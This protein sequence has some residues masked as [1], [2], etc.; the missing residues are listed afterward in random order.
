VEARVRESTA[1]ECAARTDTAEPDGIFRRIIAFLS[2]RESWALAD[3]AMVS[4]ANFLSG[5]LVARLVGLRE[6]GVFSLAWT[7][8]LFVNGIQSALITAPMVSVGPILEAQIGPCYYAAVLL[9]QSVFACVAS[10]VVEAGV[11]LSA[12]F[13]PA[14]GVRPLALPLAVSVFAYQMQDFMRRYFFATRREKLGFL[15][16]A[17][18]FLPQVLILAVLFRSHGVDSRIALWVMGLTSLA[19]FVLGLLTFGSYKIE[20]GAVRATASRHWLSS[21]WLMGSAMVQWTSGNFFLPAAAI[22][23]GPAAAGGVRAAQTLG[24]VLFVLFNSL[25]NYLPNEAA[26]RFHQRG[27][28]ALRSYL[29]TCRKALMSVAAVLCLT[30]ALSGRWLLISLYGRQYGGFAGVLAIMMATYFLTSAALP[31]RFGLRVLENTRPLFAAQVAASVLTVGT[32]FPLIAH[33]GVT[34]AAW[35]SFASQL[36]M[37]GIVTMALMSR[38]KREV[39][40]SL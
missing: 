5:I 35:A 4:V 29:R 17:V 14:W 22:V 13:W 21:K 39:D 27:I 7:S 15:N 8:V 33:F 18:S 24:Q 11:V 28:E 10:L 38:M 37:L 3:Q 19:G 31:M 6:F 26:R 34:G 25:E 1:A 2:G 32:I 12:H 23:L 16:D 9:Q 30:I 40:T 20:W 36:L